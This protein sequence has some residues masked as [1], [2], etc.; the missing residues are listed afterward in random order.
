MI[1][2]FVNKILKYKK[3]CNM[4]NFRLKEIILTRNKLFVFC[5][6][7][8]NFQLTT[9]KYKFISFKSKHS[10]FNYLK[11]NTEKARVYVTSFV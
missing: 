4:R 5:G 6:I 8:Y 10:Q 7:Y 3:K 9:L 2:N 1:Q 11:E